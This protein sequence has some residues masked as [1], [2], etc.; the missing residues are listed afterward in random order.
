MLQTQERPRGQGA[1]RSHQRRDLG[2]AYRRR[3]PVRGVRR[4]NAGEDPQGIRVAWKA[5]VKGTRE[6]SDADANYATA[7]VA[8]NCGSY[9]WSL[10]Q[11]RCNRT[12]SF[13][14]TAM[15]ARFLAFFP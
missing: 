2:A 6:E 9:G 14:A 13:R 15:T 4:R 5:R 11:R 3:S 8:L 10:T 7:R 12:A 1:K